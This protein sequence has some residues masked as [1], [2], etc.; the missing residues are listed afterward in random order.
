V[1]KFVFLILSNSNHSKESV[2]MAGVMD[3]GKQDCWEDVMSMAQ[4]GA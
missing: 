4:E 2:S 1:I 3:A